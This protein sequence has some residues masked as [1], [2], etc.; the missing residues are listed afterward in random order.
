MT[1]GNSTVVMFTRIPF[2]N[3][4]NR[5]DLNESTLR[6]RNSSLQK[7]NI[8]IE[9]FVNDIFDLFNLND[10]NKYNYEIMSFSYLIDLNEQYLNDEN[11]SKTNEAI[12]ESKKG[13]NNVKCIIL[14]RNY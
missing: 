8:P 14:W 6:A 3:V 1:I 13:N 4:I 9:N 7:S 10:S 2:T 12:I 11:T 5:C